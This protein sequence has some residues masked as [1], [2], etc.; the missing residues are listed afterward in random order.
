MILLNRRPRSVVQSDKAATPGGGIDSGGTVTANLLN[1]MVLQGTSQTCYIEAN[2][3][4]WRG[5]NE[6]QLM[7]HAWSHRRHCLAAG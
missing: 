3:A 5:A 1:H 6:L 7:P 4:A 2:H